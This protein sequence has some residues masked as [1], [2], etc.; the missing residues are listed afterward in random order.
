MAL[1]KFLIFIEILLAVLAV[2]REPV[3][4]IKIPARTQKQRISAHNLCRNKLA[5]DNI[6]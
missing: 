3:S 4:P 6:S 2:C 1:V 5:G